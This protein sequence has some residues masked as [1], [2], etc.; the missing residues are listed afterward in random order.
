VLG[1][2]QGAGGDPLLESPPVPGSIVLQPVGWKK[3]SAM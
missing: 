2:S 3:L 1:G